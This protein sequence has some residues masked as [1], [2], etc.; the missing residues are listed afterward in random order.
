MPSARR[1]PKNRPKGLSKS[2]FAIAVTSGH[3]GREPQP[4]SNTFYRP[5][6]KDEMSR[7][8]KLSVIVITPVKV[9]HQMTVNAEYSI[10]SNT[11]WFPKVA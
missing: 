10:S 11:K 2:L 1:K 7:V 4:A 5:Y 8:V 3:L 9:S 6:D